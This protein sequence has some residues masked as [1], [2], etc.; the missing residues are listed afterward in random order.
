MA[1]QK[2]AQ[3]LSLLDIGPQ[4]KDVP[5]LSGE[6]LRV[7]GISAKGMF[8]IFS[9]FPEVGKWFTAPGALDTKRFVSEVPDAMAAIIA[10]GCGLPGDTK[11]EETAELIAIDTQI[12]I[13]EAIIELT[14]KSG[15]GPFVNRIV[16][17]AGAARSVN[18][19]K[20]PG[21]NSP[22][23]SSPSLPQASDT[24]QSGT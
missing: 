14:F 3:G 19:G 16:E 4:S 15:F 1:E 2:K 7:Y 8:S 5:M 23:Q 6:S 11:A 24:T 20:A 17:I 10:A 21:T 13:L 22:Q 12:D 18:Y 9:R